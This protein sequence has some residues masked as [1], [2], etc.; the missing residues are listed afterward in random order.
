MDVTL[1]CP[2]CGRE[3]HFTDFE[4]N[5]HVSVGCIGCGE[6]LS[7]LDVLV[8]LLARVDDDTAEAAAM[9]A[10]PLREEMFQ[11]CAD[12]SEYADDGDLADRLDSMDPG[13]VFL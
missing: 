10:L 7:I 9:A 12:D 1:N 2:T 6:G 5:L 3:T 11:A 13:G 4:L 8:C